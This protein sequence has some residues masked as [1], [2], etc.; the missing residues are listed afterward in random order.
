MKLCCLFPFC[1][2]AVACSARDPSAPTAATSQADSATN[3]VGCYTDSTDRALPHEL[4]S[5]NATVASCIALA[6]AQHLAYAGLQYGGQ[7]FGGD[8]LGHTLVATSRCDMPCTANPSEVCGGLWLNSIYSTG[9]RPADSGVDATDSGDAHA[10]PKDSSG[11]QTLKALAASRGLTI[12]AGASDPQELADPKYASLVTSQFDA[13]EPANVMKMPVF[14]PA[15]NT[16]DFSQADQVV[17]FAQAHGLKVTATAPVWFSGVPDWLSHGGYS[18]AQL[19]EILHNYIVAILQHYHDNY[20]GIVSRWSVVSEATHGT[21]VWNEIPGDYVTLAY[22][23]ARA[24]DPTVELCYDDYGA[25]GMGAESD[26]VYKLVSGLKA[27]NLV[28]CVGMEGQWEGVGVGGIPSSANIISN[29]NRLGALGVSVYF[30]QMEIGVPSNVGGKPSP[31]E[32][33]DGTSALVF[34][35]TAADLQSQATAYSRLLRACLST[36][37]CKGF[38]TWGVS[39]NYAFCYQAGVCSPLLYDS[40]YAPKPAYSALLAALGE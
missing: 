33:G 8:A 34:A 16:Y 30:S 39:D 27:K 3:Y 5:S 22:Q 40:N 38:F 2:V 26:A 37:A 35:D 6:K 7:C 36:T 32:D 24:A 23:Y 21:S 10:S 29:I 9:A 17:R 4:A 1:C 28:D 11:P 19:E 13:I 15:L 20:P 31:V 12:G 18:G 25:E 14:E